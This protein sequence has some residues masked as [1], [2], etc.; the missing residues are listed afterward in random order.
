MDAFERIYEAMRKAGGEA[1]RK[2]AVRLRLGTV[3]TPS[4]LAVDVGGT[5]QE[6]ARVYLCSRLARGHAETLSLKGGAG[7]FSA[8]GGT[9]AVSIDAGSFTLIGT[10][11]AQ[12]EPVL[13]TGDQVLLLTDDDQTFYLIDK[14][15]RA[16]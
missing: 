15:V 3:L 5:T 7:G 9:H 12:A 2:G 13:R 1:A 8:N 11:A 4:P 14:V 6:A 16:T 10:A